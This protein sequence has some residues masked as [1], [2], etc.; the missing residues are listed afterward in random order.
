MKVAIVV[1]IPFS[2]RYI[3]HW[4]ANAPVRLIDQQTSSSAEKKRRTVQ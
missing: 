4:I 3:R 2:V 1:E